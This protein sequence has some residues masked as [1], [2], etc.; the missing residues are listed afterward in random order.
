ML[1]GPG[2]EQAVAAYKNAMEGND[3][4][5]L[6]VLMLNVSTDRI[7]HRFQVRDGEV[8]AYGDEGEE[9][10]RVPIKEPTVVRPAFDESLRVYRYNVT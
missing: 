4:E 1:F 8:S 3:P 6:G 9:L 2:S 10:V 7:V 5:L